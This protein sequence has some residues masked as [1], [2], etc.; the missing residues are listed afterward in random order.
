MRK[1]L[2]VMFRSVLISAQAV[3]GGIPEP[4]V[5]LY[6]KVTINGTAIPSPLPGGTDVTVL[7][8]VTGVTNPVGSYHMGDTANAAISGF[9]QYVLKI[10]LE[11]LADG[12]TQSSDHAIVSQT[13]NLFINRVPAPSNPPELSRSPAG[14][15][16]C[17]WTSVRQPPALVPWPP[18]ESATPTPATTEPATAARPPSAR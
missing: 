10:H 8:R 2:V 11:S 6:G 3:L 1:A 14:A 18:A 7:A 12:S 5:I 17:S 16:L 9:A 4:D 13:A 15:F